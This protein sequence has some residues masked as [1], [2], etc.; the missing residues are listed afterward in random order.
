MAPELMHMKHRN[1]R[2]LHRNE[3]TEQPME[4]EPQP[5][6]YYN[7]AKCDK[8][9]SYIGTSFHTIF[10]CQYSTLSGLQ[11]RLWPVG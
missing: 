4:A 7:P 5:I 10:I 8:L 9:G 11:D 2:R 3:A 1:M 6:S